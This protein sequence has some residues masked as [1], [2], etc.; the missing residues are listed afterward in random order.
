[1]YFA[2][3]RAAALV[4][5]PPPPPP[6]EHLFSAS[7]SDDKFLDLLKHKGYPEK[8]CSKLTGNWNPEV[9]VCLH[10]F[11]LIIDV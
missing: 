2:F 8:D 7:M 5:S 11:V 4:A 3:F 6:P 9:C 10:S 1:M